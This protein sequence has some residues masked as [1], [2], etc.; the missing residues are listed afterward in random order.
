MTNLLLIL[1]ILF[2]SPCARAN[3]AG[4][5]SFA[6]QVND[7]G[8][9]EE[10]IA[11]AVRTRLSEVWLSENADAIQAYNKRVESQGVF[12]DGLRNF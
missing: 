1:L 9:A 8:L 3:A 4:A 12:S 2:L 10:A 7:E 5:L 11:K 6:A